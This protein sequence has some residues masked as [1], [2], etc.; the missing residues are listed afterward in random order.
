[1]EIKRVDL[2]NKIY[3]EID[4]KMRKNL[5]N[6]C[7]LYIDE[8]KN[9][10]LEDRYQTFKTQLIEKRGEENVKEEYLFHGTKKPYID[11]I[12]KD[13]FK[14]ALNKVCAYGIGTYLSPNAKLALHY[15][16]ATVGDQTFL[17]GVEVSYVFFCKVLVGKKVVGKANQKLNTELYDVG[18]NSLKI[19]THLSIPYDEAIVPKYIVAFYK[20]AS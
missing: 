19:P 8:I 5:E 15:T 10:I 2:G 16:D 20:N 17:D 9:D 4:E 1:M 3:D 6:C 7:I 12:S 11:S 14:V 13:G 18:V